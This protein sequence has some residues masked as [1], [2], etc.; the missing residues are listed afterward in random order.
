MVYF[1]L[2]NLSLSG[3][4]KK[5]VKRATG[6]FR[7]QEIRHKRVSDIDYREFL[8]QL[9]PSDEVVLFGGDGTLN[10]FVNAVRGMDIRFPVFACKSGTGNDF[11][12][13]VMDE[14]APEG[15]LFQ[16]N[17][18]LQGL[19]EATIDG[20]DYFFFNNASFGMDGE[21]C[22][23]AEEQKERGKK[24]SNYT[25]IAAGLLMRYKPVHATVVVDG[26]TREF[27]NVWIAATMNGRYFG[28]GMKVAPTQNRD[29]ETL[30]LCVFTCKSRLKTMLLFP[31]IFPG[32][33]IRHRDNFIMMEGREFEIRYDTEKDIQLDGEVFRNHKVIRVRK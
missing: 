4:M 29:N 1:L 25:V 16:I 18:Y 8:S 9:D 13:D 2:N 21:V 24:K 20:K 19:P 31:Q 11:L 14:R 12:R 33:H 27:E 32:I 26:V 28:G 5:A 30:T 6:S 22:T 10:Y 3:K 23:I 17:K 7:D 15:T